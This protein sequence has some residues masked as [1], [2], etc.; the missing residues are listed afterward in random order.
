ME[1]QKLVC[2]RSTSWESSHS[3]R[4]FLRL[5]F[6]GTLAACGVAA[7]LSQACTSIP[8]PGSPAAATS[9]SP[10]TPAAS[11]A[12][13]LPTY[14]PLPTVKAD[15]PGTDTVPDA[16]LAYPKT[17]FKS[18]TSTPGAGGEVTWMTYTFVPNAPL[19]DNAMWQEVNKQVGATLR[20]QLTAY[21][22]YQT[23]LSSVL[24]GG[25][26]PDV[27]YIP[28]LQP[29]LGHLLQAKFADLTP[30]VSGDAVKDYPNL[31][32]L[33]TLAWKNTVFN[34]AI[35]AV[36]T[37][38]VPFFWVLWNRQD[39]LEQIGAAPPTTA[40]EFKRVLGELVHAQGG[41]WG[42]ASHVNN[43]FDTWNPSGGMYAAMFGAPNQWSETGGKFTRTFET[44]QFRAAVGFARDLYAAGVYDP[45][46]LT[47]NILSKRTQFEA[48]RFA[49]DFDGM[50]IDMW[51]L[52]KKANPNARL[53][54]PV[55]PSGDGSQGHYWFG[56]G[57][58]GF[59]AIRQASPD[60]IKEILRI[61]NFLAAPMGSEEYLLTN[62]GV[63]GIDF[64]FDD[65]GNPTPTAKGQADTMPWG[66]ASA[67]VPRP[68]RPL[69]NPLDPEFARVIQND[70][71]VMAEFGVHD[72]SIGLYSNTDANK[73]NV[74]N[75]AMLDGITEIVKGTQP[76]SSLDQLVQDW[77]TNG[78]EQ[79]RAELEQALASA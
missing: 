64:E 19:E 34:S 51:N 37:A 20:M 74:L 32:N 75:Q 1:R 10:G 73:S 23:R 28:G 52:S 40:D 25:D 62:F 42:I 31:A 45:D 77:R 49:Y 4:A 61:M 2:E 65:N 70:D 56:P 63:R 29:E 26:L 53:R 41:T 15:L 69:F 47:Y 44:E 60:R 21:A 57:V 13:R 71:K 8:L 35:Y 50:N 72:P 27:V 33:P 18:V 11:G 55:P 6:G 30:Y 5:S 3:R 14:A 54:Q 7:L 67:T 43:A 66:G 22:D 68:P 58:F 48:G 76:L 46:S 12:L 17:S 59:T 24:A 36:P 79:I 39:M 16:Y 9:R 78:G 38:F